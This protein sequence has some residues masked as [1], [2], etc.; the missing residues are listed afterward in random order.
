MGY[1]IELEESTIGITKDNSVKMMDMLV[2]YINNNKVYWSWV[3]EEYI[4][5]ACIEHIFE[6]VMEEFR[7]PVYE[8]DGIYKIEY[9]SGEKLGDDYEIFS[10]IAPYINDGY[11]EMCGEDGLR[12]RWIF[13]NGICEEKYPEIEW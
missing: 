2:D 4:A 3:N 12:W 1:C 5:G 9:F 11:I 7:Y 10:L 13:K 8:E 6:E